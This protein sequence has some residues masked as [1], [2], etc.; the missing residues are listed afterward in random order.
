MKAG[1]LAWDNSRQAVRAR[2]AILDGEIA[3]LAA[4]GSSRFYNLLFR[5]DWP[6]FLAFDVLC[7][8]GEDLRH[9]PLLER[10]RRLARIMPRIES[11]LM[12][13][14]PIPARGKRLYELACERDLEG[15]VAK[16]SKGSYQ[17]GG[18]GT[19]WLKVKNPQYSQAERRHELFEGVNNPGVGLVET[20][21]SLRWHCA[22]ILPKV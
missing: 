8:D 15:I 6:H 7:I 11:R 10:K 5:R 22:S 3:C 20:S 9:L 1:G 12:L 14:K 18:R 17:C 4:D 19:S 13:L 21:A 2:S 16:W